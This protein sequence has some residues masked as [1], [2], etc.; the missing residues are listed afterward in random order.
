MK[1][2]APRAR[3]TIPLLVLA[4][5][6]ICPSFHAG[7]LLQIDWVP[8]L[9]EAMKQALLRNV[10][11]LVAVCNDVPGVDSDGRVTTPSEAWSCYRSPGVVEAS[12]NLV[13]LLASL[14]THGFG[15]TTGKAVC[16]VF[17]KVC[18]EDHRNAAEVIRTRYLGHADLESSWLLILTPDGKVLDRWPHAR[19]ADALALAMKSA[20]VLYQDAA[21]DAIIRSLKTGKQDAKA[22]AFSSALKFL[23]ADGDPGRLE[24]AVSKHLKRLRRDRDRR[25]AWSAIEQDG[26]E[27]A[28][29]LLLPALA[30]KSPRLRKEA[31]E[32]YIHGEAYA[33]FLS[34][35]CRRVYKE[36]SESVLLAL[37]GVLEVYASKFPGAVPALN[38]L[39]VHGSRPVQVAATLAAAWPGNHAI[40]NALLARARGAGNPAVRSSAIL[41]LAQMNAGKARAALKNIRRKMGR[42]SS[43]AR[44]LDLA[45]ARLEGDDSE[46]RA[47][48]DERD[49]LRRG[50]DPAGNSDDDLRRDRTERRSRAQN[51]R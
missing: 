19:G 1:T 11:I 48:H 4:L 27:G 16:P 9:D 47:F 46:N 24:K 37:V 40:Y 5:A 28:L 12:R 21:T 39:V 7:E 42:K 43:L 51:G 8:N 29:A 18:C 26:S 14:D 17:G 36:K 45:I 10:P 20:R 35:L 38:R 44:V 30:E 22:A 31:L 32:V 34:P 6:V 49:R 15:E 33:S 50:V 25:A 3:R 23:S 13:C 41:G 2:T